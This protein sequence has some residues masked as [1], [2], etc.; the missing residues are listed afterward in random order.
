[1]VMDR[2]ALL[3]ALA[4][5]SSGTS[6]GLSGRPLPPGHVVD[7]PEVGPLYWVSEGAPSAGEMAAARAQSAASGLW[8]LLVDGGGSSIAHELGA[9]GPQEKLAY[10]LGEGRPSNVA[11]VEP[12]RWLEERWRE[13]IPENEANFEP[14]ERV[15]S[16]APAGKR[17][18][19]LAPASNQATGADDCA[20][21]MSSF[22]LDNR[23]LPDPRLVLIPAAAGSDALIAAR[24]TLADIDDLAGHAAVLRSWEQRFGARL[25]ALRS[26]TMFVSVAG[27]PLQRSA[28]VHI[29]CEHFAFAPDNVEQNADSFPEYVEGF[30][31]TNMWSFWWD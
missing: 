15:S 5:D 12:E 9:G 28:A 11:E 27:R 10:W 22:L 18:P 26:N 24:C 16:L 31:G 29:A 23:W 13:L 17:W 4:Q 14:D 20:D 21:A 30:M 7:V 25:I 19:R 8:P 3:S 6:V 2:A 1:M